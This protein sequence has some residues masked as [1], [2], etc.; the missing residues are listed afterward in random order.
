MKKLAIIT[1]ALFIT[2]TLAASIGYE[3]ILR[4]ILDAPDYL[5]KIS[6]QETQV[7]IGLLLALTNSAAVVGIAVTLFPILSQHHQALALGYLAARIVESVTF[8]VGLLSLLALLTA[9][10]A[11]VPTGA[12]DATALRAS[13]TLLL[14][15]YDWSF[16]L[17]VTL[18]LGLTALILNYV[19]Y[20]S[21][22]VPRLISI[23]GLLAGALLFVQ[24]VWDLFGTGPAFLS[25]P[26]A[27]QEMVLAVWLIVK[28]FRPSAVASRSAG[29]LPPVP[30]A[31][32]QPLKTGYS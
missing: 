9:G 24:G 3:G 12:P 23:W 22:L 8:V 14:A 19:L 13:S 29:P 4:P 2:A 7:L 30:T 31:A 25:F 11:L 28:G 15:I 32:D 1:G 27:L 20:R 6:E 26:I 10:Q 17:A 16:W 21:R 18:V 5:V